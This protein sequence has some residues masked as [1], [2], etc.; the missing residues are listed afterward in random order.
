MRVYDTSM[1]ELDMLWLVCAD[2]PADGVRGADSLRSR[3]LPRTDPLAGPL[4]HGRDALALHVRLGRLLPSCW[5]SIRTARYPHAVSPRAAS[6]PGARTGRQT[7]RCRRRG[8]ISATTSSSIA[9]GSSGSTSTSPSAW[10]ALSLALV[11]LTALVTFLA[12]IA[13]W[14]IEKP[15]SRLP[16]SGADARNR[17]DRGVSLRRSLLFYV[18]YEVMLLPMYFLDRPLGRRHA[19]RLRGDQVRPL[20]A[21]RR[22]RH[23]RRVHRPLHRERARLRRSERGE[24]RSRR[25]RRVKSGAQPGRALQQ[26]EVHS[27]DPSLSSRAAGGDAADPSGQEDRLGRA[28]RRPVALRERRAALRAGRGPCGSDLQRAKG[29]AAVFTQLPV[30]DSSCCCSSASRSRCRSSRCTPGCPTPTSRRRRR[31]A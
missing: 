7:R 21:A 6:K 11:I 26:V 22:R 9:R 30:P 3:P 17:R 27:F 28:T 25:M 16:R 8:H 5:S 19:A 15:V 10:T 14:K 20:H 4:R 1:H 31:S 24:E 12:V 23:P 18:F 13:S 2:L 29:V